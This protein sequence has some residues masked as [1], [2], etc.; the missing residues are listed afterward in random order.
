[1]VTG[2]SRRLVNGTNVGPIKHDYNR[3]KGLVEQKMMV[4]S[5]GD[6]EIVEEK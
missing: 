6:F 5:K 2:V 4:L 1:V 3:W